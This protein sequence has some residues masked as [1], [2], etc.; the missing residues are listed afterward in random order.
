V[1]EFLSQRKVPFSERNVAI[2]QQAAMEMVQRTGQQGVPVTII[3]GE[4]VI[5]FDKSRL[6][7]ILAQKSTAGP[8]HLGASVA[9][10][11]HVVSEQGQGFA[12]G[13]YV[14]GVKPGSLA[15][16]IGLRKDDIIVE[17]AGQSINTAS[18]IE[19]VVRTLRGGQ[20]VTVT[21]L[22]H[23]KRERLKFVP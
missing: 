10:A 14:G 9:D 13:A 18:D 23:G 17:L 8:V 20:P 12:S 3:D 7:Q 6:E 11:A 15:E 21:F 2:D 4:V 5:G 1:K 19:K 22:R 16:R